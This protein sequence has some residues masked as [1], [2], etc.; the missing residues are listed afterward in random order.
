VPPTAPSS[1]RPEI[2]GGTDEAEAARAREELC[3]FTLDL[4]AL[5]GIEEV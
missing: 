4:A 3:V 2:V 5:L 1:H